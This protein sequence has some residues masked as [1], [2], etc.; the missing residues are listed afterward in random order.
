MRRRRVSLTV[1]C[2]PLVDIF[3]DSVCVSVR[4]KFTYENT[5]HRCRRRRRTGV[6]N[7]FL[8]RI[9]R[10]LARSPSAALRA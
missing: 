2:L 4:P 6:K 10:A 1:K 5:R 8:L 3:R 9:F 7:V